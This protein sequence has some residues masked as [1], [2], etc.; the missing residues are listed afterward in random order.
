M[1]QRKAAAKNQDSKKPTTPAPAEDPVESLSEEVPTSGTPCG[2]RDGL[3]E[4][5][6]D[7]SRVHVAPEAKKQMTE[8]G[9]A[10][11]PGMAPFNMFDPMM[12]QNMMLMYLSQMQNNLSNAGTVPVQTNTVHCGPKSDVSENRATAGIPTGQ[13]R[14]IPDIPTLDPDGVTALSV[15]RCRKLLLEYEFVAPSLCSMTLSRSS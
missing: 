10:Q 13:L 5:D 9:P 1:M 2:A 4:V 15:E 6:E 14:K 11:I 12:F 7:T 8:K 3:V